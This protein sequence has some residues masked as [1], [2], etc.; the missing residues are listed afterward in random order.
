LR[1]APDGGARL[2]GAILVVSAA[3]AVPGAAVEPP[4]RLVANG[5]PARASCAD[6]NSNDHP[7]LVRLAADFRDAR[8]AAT[9]PVVL[10]AAPDQ[11]IDDHGIYP[12]TIQI[13]DESVRLDARVVLARRRQRRSRRRPRR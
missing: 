11:D 8:S 10:A 9:V 12:L 6:A 13:A 2:D 1:I 7:G 5:V 3:D 4:T